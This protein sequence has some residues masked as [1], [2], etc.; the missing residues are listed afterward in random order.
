[1]NFILL[2]W[3]WP[4]WV[5]IFAR[6]KYILYI[7][8]AWQLLIRSVDLLII[9]CKCVVLYYKK[10]QIY[11]RAFV[12]SPINPTDTYKIPSHFGFT[13]SDYGSLTLNSYSLMSFLLSWNLLCWPKMSWFMAVWPGHYSLS[14]LLIVQDIFKLMWELNHIWN[15]SLPVLFG[16]YFCCSRTSPYF[17]EVSKCPPPAFEQ[18]L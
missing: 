16:Q 11:P 2:T 7:S 8:F 12:L 15:L 14:V 9:T 1:M 17:V 10:Y 13:L 6:I 3:R 4:Y 18:A 5:K